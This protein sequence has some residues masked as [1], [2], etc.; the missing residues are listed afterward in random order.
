[1][2][3]PIPTNPYLWL[4][5]VIVIAIVAYS[6]KA[7]KPVRS[8]QIYNTT[9]Y[10]RADINEASKVPA[11]PNETAINQLLNN[12]QLKKIT[13]FFSPNETGLAGVEGTEI[14]Y[15]LTYHYLITRGKKIIFEGKPVSNFTNSATKENV[16]IYLNKSSK[17]SIKLVNNTIYINYANLRQA[18]L[19]TV[20]LILIALGLY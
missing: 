5:F 10:F 17:A 9:F 4:I 20:K 15:K 6:L 18:D 11:Y 1:M 16:Y 7:P 12:E 8:L 2:K 19:A 13:I 14:S 3:K